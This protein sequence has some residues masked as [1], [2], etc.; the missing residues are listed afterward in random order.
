[1]LVPSWFHLWRLW[2]GIETPIL[3]PPATVDGE[4]LS[5]AGAAEA[6]GAV[7]A[8][9]AA[10]ELS[11]GALLPQAESENTIA[12]AR[13][14]AKIFFIS[15]TPVFLDSYLNR[16]PADWKQVDQYK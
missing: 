15:F 12:D 4:P 6:A 7:E 14:L 13:I 3:P 8:A 5:S 1:M 10:F 16:S 9:G 11:A 2:V